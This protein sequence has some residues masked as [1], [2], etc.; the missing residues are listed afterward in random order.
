MGM[1]EVRDVKVPSVMDDALDIVEL[2]NVV[3]ETKQFAPVFIALD[4]AMQ[5]GYGG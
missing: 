1:N 5:W 2:G 3:E 4:S